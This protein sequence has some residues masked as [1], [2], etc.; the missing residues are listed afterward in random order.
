MFWD[1][2]K[3]NYFKKYNKRKLNLYENEISFLAARQ[4]WAFLTS[5]Q[6][7][8]SENDKLLVLGRVLLLLKYV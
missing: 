7:I 6:S 5:I 2:V 4:Q 1:I 3:E 8:L